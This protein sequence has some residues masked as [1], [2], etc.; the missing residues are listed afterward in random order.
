MSIKYSAIFKG[1]TLVE[2]LFAL[3]IFSLLVGAASWFLST[4]LRTNKVLWADL[5]AQSDG[6]RVM[7]KIVEEVRRTEQSNIGAYPIESATT[8]TL[9]FFAN[10][11]TDTDRERVRY[12]LTSSTILRGVTNPTGSPSVYVT[13]SEQVVILGQNIV[14]IAQNVPLF[15]YYGEDY[16]GV[17]PPLTNPVSSTQVHAIRVQVEIEDNPL[18]SPILFHGQTF[19]QLRNLKTN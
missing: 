15:S 3:G 13:S 4:T 5:A 18:A 12:S 8:N 10:I 7:E 16:T 11:D 6:R 14:N 2:I 19:V 1:T 9:I 17:E